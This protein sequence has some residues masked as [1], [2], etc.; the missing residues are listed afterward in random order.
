[1]SEGT[2]L[3]GTGI[4]VQNGPA[5]LVARERGWIVLV[6]GSRKEVI[7]AAWEVLGTGGSADGPS[8]ETLLEDI[9]RRAGIESPTAISALLFALLDEGTTRIGVR[10]STPLAVHT[11]DGVELVVG[12]DEEPLAVRELSGVRRIAFGD[13]P[14]EDPL[15]ALRVGTGIVRARG[16]VHSLVDPTSLPE[17]ER[18]ALAEQIAEQ[19]RS[20][21][22]PDARARRDARP[23]PTKNVVAPAATGASAAPAAPAAPTAAPATAPPPRRSPAV[24]TRR[25]GEMPGSSPR[26]TPAPAASSAPSVFDGLF[27]GPAPEARP[28]PAP[29]SAPAAAPAPAVASPVPEP[30]P[31]PAPAPAA[32]PEPVV[33]PSVPEPAGPSAPP[34]PAAGQAPAA[35]PSRGRRRLVSTSLFD[36]PRTPTPQ[37]PT[38]QAPTPQAPA[39]APAAAAEPSRTPHP[40]ART[41]P[42]T[43]SADTLIEPLESFFPETI[44]EPIEQVEQVEPSAPIP[45][46]APAAAAA[47]GRRRAATDSSPAAPR[48]DREPGSAPVIEV[49]GERGAY[50]DLFGSTIYRSV[51]DAAVRK[52]G[53][54]EHVE[55]GAI[56]PESAAGSG[57]GVGGGAAVADDDPAGVAITYG[58]AE[59]APSNLPVARPAEATSSAIG[60]D[61]IDWVP[62]VGR[63]APEVARAEARRAAAP[64]Q[65]QAPAPVQAAAVPSP[66]PA[67][68]PSAQPGPH[69]G[70]V[71]L[72]GL[73]CPSGHAESPERTVCRVCRGPLQGPPRAVA[74]P[75][76]GRIAILSGGGFVLDRTAIV[77][78]RPRA[79]RVS[80]HDVPQLITVPSPQQDISRSHVE[81][82]L[83]GWHVVASDLGTTNGTTLLRQGA[84]P[85]RLRPREGMVLVEGDRLDLGDGTILQYREAP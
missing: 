83:E 31:A 34:V 35:A 77:G 33:A 43:S 17:A 15:G 9:A 48:P 61:F 45:P 3:L 76:L 10:G 19:G 47:T 21:I 26:R 84:E 82:H 44:I 85:V 59:A 52:S 80:G 58:R 46:V 2:T 63:A 68:A 69:S 74:R 79:S 8:A 39:P 41:G 71:M 32:A 12:S 22:T 65:A 49:S 4:W 64:A 24:A 72:P 29:Q 54:E 70:A 13:L 81:L 27:G 60:G 42:P 38:P 57:P 14:A 73:L 66:A 30:A 37:A 50:D 53:E 75:P 28:A 36:S 1:M 55:E 20:I 6:P 23:A 67:P 51:E 78:R 18:S 16:F 5:T 11:A 7:E 40:L 25:S 62:G 56:A